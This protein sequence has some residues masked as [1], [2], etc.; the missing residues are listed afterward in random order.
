MLNELD[1][2]RVTLF[3][4]NSIGPEKSYERCF[5][6]AEV[7]HIVN[8]PKTASDCIGNDVLSFLESHHQLELSSSELRA[9]ERLVMGPRRVKSWLAKVRIPSMISVTALTESFSIHQIRARAMS[10]A[11]MQADNTVNPK[12][13]QPDSMNPPGNKIG[14]DL[15]SAPPLDDNDQDARDLSFE[16]LH[17]VS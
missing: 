13:A 11:V 10:D 16:S 1:E 7:Q 8:Y 2:K 17:A 12:P 6:P 5:F 9:A 3:A 4:L 14:E 15:N